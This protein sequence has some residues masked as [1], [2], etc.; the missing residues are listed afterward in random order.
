[1]THHPTT[2]KEYHKHTST[3][4]SSI[5]NM[6]YVHFPFSMLTKTESIILHIS[7]LSFMVFILYGIY[8][9]LPACAMTALSQGYFYIFGDPLE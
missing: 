9:Y 3:T 5:Y 4:C 8:S 7:V 1:M 2:S 6:Y